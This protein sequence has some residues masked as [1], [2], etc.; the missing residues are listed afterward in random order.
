MATSDPVPTYGARNWCVVGGGL[1]GLTLAHRLAEAGERVTVLE[2]AP[3]L[4]GLASAW[5]LGDVIWD[6]HYHV[7]MLSDF[8]LRRLLSELDLEREIR[9]TVTRTGFYCDDHL[10]RLN[11]AIDY[12]RFSPLGLI[13]K[14]RLATTLHRMSRI[15]DGRK[16]ER[17]PLTD[18]LIR[19]SGKRTFEKIWRPLLRAKMG[20]NYAKASAAFIWAYVNRLYA[21]R[22]GGLKTEMFGYV[23]GSYARILERLE[24]MLTA[25]GVTIELASPVQ[26]IERTADGVRVTTPRGETDFDQVVVTAAGPLAARMCA[27]LTADETE[28]LNGVLYQGIVCA[29]VLLKR[30]LAGYYVTYIADE[31]VPFTGVI[32]MSALVDPAEHFGGHAL[33]YLP[34]YAVAGDPYFEMSDDEVEERFLAGLAKIYP[35]IGRDDVLAFRIS[36]VRNV[37]AISTLNYSDRLPPMTTSVAG[38]HIVNSAQIVNASLAVNESVALAEQAVPRLLAHAR[39]DPPRRV[40][41]QEPA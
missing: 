16:L 1:L 7:I 27:G 34:R 5:R 15:K 33:V 22:R 31:A 12:L 35:A 32:E 17:I 24:G 30:P 14:V 21:A 29:S 37:Y 9:W 11:N 10:Y 23:P 40:R 2:A 26:R 8:Y 4:G 28:R 36:R 41:E 6:R 20:E 13:D 3:T 19:L 39:A 18:W 25:E 38:V